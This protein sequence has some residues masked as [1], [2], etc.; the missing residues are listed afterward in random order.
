MR[1]VEIRESF[2]LEHLA[3]S[4]RSEPE[5]GPGRVLVKMRVADVDEGEQ[6]VDHP[7]PF[8]ACAGDETLNI[9]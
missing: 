8:T 7:K 1:V 6:V 2:G 9:T 4:T 3:L 5:P